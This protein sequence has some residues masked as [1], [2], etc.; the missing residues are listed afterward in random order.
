MGRLKAGCK[1]HFILMLPLLSLMISD[2][3][4]LAVGSH[5]KFWSRGVIAWALYFRAGVPSF[6]VWPSTSRQVSGSSGLEMKCTINVMCLWLLLFSR[7]VVSNSATLW[8]V[9]CQVPLF[10]SS[11]LSLLL[12]QLNH[13][14]TIPLPGPWK[15]CLPGNLSLVPKVLGTT[16]LEIVCSW[17]AQQ[18]WFGTW[19]PPLNDAPHTG[20]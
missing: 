17:V 2:F 4:F 18:Q 12:M 14:Q 15:N 11:S 13:P 5:S 19:D 20:L 16:V 1:G 8:T 9:A 3:V 10:F 7:P 6:R